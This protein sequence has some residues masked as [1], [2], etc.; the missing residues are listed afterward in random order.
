MRCRVCD[1]FF[2]PLHTFHL[3]N[4]P[5]STRCW[6]QLWASTEIYLHRESKLNQSKLIGVKVRDNTKTNYI[7]TV[8]LWTINRNAFGQMENGME[9]RY[10]IVDRIK[11]I[12][13]QLKLLIEYLQ[14]VYYHSECPY[15]HYDAKIKKKS[16]ARRI[17]SLSF[18][19]DW[20][21]CIIVGLNLSRNFSTRTF[22]DHSLIVNHN[23]VY[24]VEWSLWW[25]WNC[26]KII[27]CVSYVAIRRTYIRILILIVMRGELNG[28][29]N[30]VILY[31]IFLLIF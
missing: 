9:R 6:S 11:I 3:K 29:Q 5:F 30:I 27:T 23:S 4:K 16:S 15:C 28:S 19:F 10:A 22:A 14:V 18:T 2:F 21:N 17:D 25:I 13:L 8:V 24:T 20:M 7:I 31:W 1:H 12:N 26:Y